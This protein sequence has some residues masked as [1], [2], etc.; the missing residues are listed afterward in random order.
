[1]AFKDHDGIAAVVASRD[2]DPPGLPALVGG[3]AENVALVQ[4]RTLVIRLKIDGRQTN[5]CLVAKVCVA[6][7]PG[8]TSQRGKKGVA[9]AGIHIAWGGQG[10]LI[11]HDTVVA[12]AQS[13]ELVKAGG[14][15]GG[16]RDDGA[17]AGVLQQV[18]SDATDAGF[19]ASF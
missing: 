2:R 19:T 7:L 5:G 12:A 18:H 1:V 11:H 9:G 3:T 15:G 14:A 16:R 4:G 6:Y 13:G 10:A 17:M 8:P